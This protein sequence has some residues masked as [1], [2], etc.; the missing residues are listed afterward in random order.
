M[1]RIPVSL[2]VGFLGSGKTTLLRH[3]LSRRPPGQ[4]WACVVNEFGAVDVDGTRLAGSGA[5]IVPIPGGS[6]F[7]QCLVTQFIEVLR[8][9]ARADAD[10]PL[11]G[12]LIEAS[13][14]ADPRVVRRLFAE[15]GQEQYS[16]ATIVALVDPGTYFKLRQTLPNLQ[17]QIE[18]A[19]H[20]VLNKVDCHPEPLIQE[21]EA[22]LRKV[23]S[24]A[25][26][27]RCS[28]GQV[29][30]DPFGPVAGSPSFDGYYAPCR[31]PAFATC[32]VIHRGAV[33]ESRFRAAVE[34]VAEHLYRVKGHLRINGCLQAV[35]YSDTGL[36]FEPE[37]RPDCSAQLVVICRGDRE[38]EVRR[39]LL[40]PLVRGEFNPDG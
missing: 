14:V 6:I 16:I 35:D 27:H 5:D 21:T 25:R 8:R 1:S 11:D 36:V 34:A 33:H 24:V 32:H 37:R 31:D 38:E 7:C 9:L 19:D 12:V 4:H 22:E 23:N 18:T 17:A 39:T 29:N 3:L 15:T 40:R 10:R 13:G 30:L 26:L 2:I 20:L 28:F